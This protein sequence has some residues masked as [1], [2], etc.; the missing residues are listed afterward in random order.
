MENSIDDVS[1]DQTN[2]ESGLF[3]TL[4]LGHLLNVFFLYPFS[5]STNDEK[6]QQ[7][8]K[9]SL[10]IKPR[11]ANAIKIFIVKKIDDEKSTELSSDMIRYTTI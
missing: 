4:R 10:V 7:S 11:D 5:V 8:W 1:V 9:K 3:E 6:Q 2:D